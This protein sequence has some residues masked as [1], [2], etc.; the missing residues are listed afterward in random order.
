MCVSIMKRK[1]LRVRGLY[2][3]LINFVKVQRLIKIVRHLE[4]AFTASSQSARLAK[5]LL[6]KHDLYRYAVLAYDHDL[7]ALSS[8]SEEFSKALFPPL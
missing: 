4:P 3:R 6:R 5:K 7:F 1:T 2:A 8:L